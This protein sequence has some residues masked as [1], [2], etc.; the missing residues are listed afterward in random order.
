MNV[1][2]RLTTRHNKSSCAK[3]DK[4][5][6]QNERIKENHITMSSDNKNTY[7]KINRI[8]AYFCCPKSC[9]YSF[10]EF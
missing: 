3:T 10:G 1:V 6:S 9:V 4:S 2:F 7:D 5:H 8:L